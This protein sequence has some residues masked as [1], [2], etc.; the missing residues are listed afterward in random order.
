MLSIDMI[1]QDNV[2]ETLDKI[3]VMTKEQ[4]DTQYHIMNYQ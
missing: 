2:Y 4:D 1:S 3:I